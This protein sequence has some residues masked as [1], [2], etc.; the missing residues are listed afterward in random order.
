MGLLRAEL[1]VSLFFLR[2]RKFWKIRFDF[3][4]G[5]ERVNLK[6]EAIKRVGLGGEHF[7]M[8]SVDG[9]PQF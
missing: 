1:R 7:G 5:S 3:D 4:E 6:S 8:D 2:Y 9:N